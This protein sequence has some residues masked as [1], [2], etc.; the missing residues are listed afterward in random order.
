[1]EEKDGNKVALRIIQ[2]SDLHVTSFRNLLSPMVEAINHEQVDLVVVTGDTTHRADDKDAF[3]DVSEALNKINHRVVVIPGDYDNG[4]LWKE[5]FGDGRLKSFNLNGFCLDFLDTSFMKHRYAVGWADVLKEEDPEQYEWLMEQL[6]VDKYH[7]IF[8]HHPFWTQPTQAGDDYLRDNVRAVYS[9]HLRE[10]VKFYF[11]YDNPRSHFPHGFTCVPMKFHGNA[12][13][14][15][16]A[17]KLNGDMVNF[18]KMVSA[19][20]TAW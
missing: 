10:P 2:I 6:K 13:Y 3:R 19:K 4:E 9:G 15:L 7:L 18:P 20:R 8:S 1:M 12:C 14:I 17:V 16:I 11:K 5:S